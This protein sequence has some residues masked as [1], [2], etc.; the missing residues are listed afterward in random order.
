VKRDRYEVGPS[1]QAQIAEGCR[2][3][4]V[5]RNGEVLC[6][7]DTQAD[8]IELVMVVARTRLKDLNQT[9]ELFIKGR[10]GKVRDARTYGDD[11]REIPG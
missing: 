5:T 3:W 7:C 2:K 8:G 6:F 11:P 1:S 9:A 4:R 10:N